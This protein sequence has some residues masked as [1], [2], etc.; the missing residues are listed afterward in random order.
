[1]LTVSLTRPTLRPRLLLFHLGGVCSMS[2]LLR[3]FIGVFV[4]PACISCSKSIAISCAGLTPS[5]TSSRSFSMVEHFLHLGVG[6]PG[7]VTN[8]T[9]AECLAKAHPHAEVHRANGTL[10]SAFS[11]KCSGPPPPLS[12]D[13]TQ[14]VLAR[15]IIK[16]HGGSS[17]CAGRFR[18]VL[19]VPFPGVLGC[20]I[21]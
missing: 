17:T 11:T 7:L 18:G 10:Q 1:M 9:C 4:P 3:F 8:A 20:S 19:S 2:I 5:L 14:R 13:L 21:L 6:K 12:V 15:L 16:G